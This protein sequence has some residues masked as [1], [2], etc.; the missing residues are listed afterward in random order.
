MKKRYRYPIDSSDAPET[1]GSSLV[2]YLGQ[3]WFRRMVAGGMAAPAITGCGATR[4]FVADEGSDPRQTG[5]AL[6]HA[7]GSDWF[8]R[9]VAG[10][11]A[12]LA[13][14]VAAVEEQRDRDAPTLQ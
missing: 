9:M 6:A 7:F 4:H 2:F 5:N 11:E 14:I 3:T 12:S 8:K 10:G 13:A 1:V